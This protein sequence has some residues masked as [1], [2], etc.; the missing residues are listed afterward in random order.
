MGQFPF[1]FHLTPCEERVNTTDQFHLVPA[2]L[3]SIPLVK[4]ENFWNVQM[5]LSN[6]SPYAS[7]GRSR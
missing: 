6:V 1:N 4:T 3:D 5:L 2:Y 7:S